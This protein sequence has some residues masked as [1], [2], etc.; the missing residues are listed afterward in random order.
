M[1]VDLGSAYGKIVIDTT[2]LQNGVNDATTALGGLPGTAKRVGLGIAAGIGVAGAA[3]GGLAVSSASA[4][5]DMETQMSN[6]AAVMNKPIDE[7][8]PLNSLIK[9]LG[10]DPGLKVDAVEAGQAIEMLAKNGLSMQEVLDGAA[11]S[12]VLLAN[13]TGAD[14]ATAADIGTDAMAIFGI[15]AENMSEAVN[16]ITSVTTNSKFD[17]NDYGLAIGAGG[18]RRLCCRRRVW[19]LQRGDYSHVPSVCIRLGCWHLIQDDAHAA[20]P[21]I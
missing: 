2:G 21:G 4:A 15:S 19:R 9:E 6:I 5:A 18:R 11:H 10:L 3:V 16:G 13:S 8:E 7:I 12:T 1:S 14:F 17:V 20:N